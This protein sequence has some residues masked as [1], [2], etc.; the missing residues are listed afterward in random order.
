MSNYPDFDEE[1]RIQQQIEEKD[2]LI[3]DLG[4]H[5]EMLKYMAKDINGLVNEQGELLDDLSKKVDKTDKHIV[6]STEKVK[7][8]NIKVETSDKRNLIIIGI[9]MIILVAII[10]LAIIF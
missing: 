7:K 3:D 1:N 2:R 5:T 9:Q 6:K 10:I 4:V 8:V